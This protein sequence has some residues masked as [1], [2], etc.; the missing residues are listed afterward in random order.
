MKRRKRVEGENAR[1][2][3]WNCGHLKDTME[4]ECNRNFIKYTKAILMSSPNN[5]RYGF[6]TGHLLSPN[7]AYRSRT[8]PMEI[9]KQPRLLRQWVVFH[10]LTAGPHCQASN[11]D[12]AYRAR[13]LVYH[14]DRSV[15]A[16]I[17][18]EQ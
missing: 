12:L 17:A 16:G 2:D 15:A 7:R 3:S 11:W 10:K 1:I 8:I 6:L 4:T 13:S 14:I 18:L 5:G 9:H